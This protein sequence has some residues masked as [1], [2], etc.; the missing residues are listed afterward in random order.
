[1]APCRDRR[2]PPRDDPLLIVVSCPVPVWPCPAAARIYQS[3][4]ELCVPRHLPGPCRRH[5]QRPSDNRHMLPVPI[6]NDEPCEKR[7]FVW[8]REK[9]E[10]QMKIHG[11]HCRASIL[12]QSRRH[13]PAAV[14]LPGHRKIGVTQQAIESASHFDIDIFATRRRECVIASTSEMPVASSF[15][16]KFKVPLRAIP[17]T[18]YSVGIFF[19]RREQVALAAEHRQTLRQIGYAPSV[20]HQRCTRHC[21]NAAAANN[22]ARR[23]ATPAAR[24]KIAV[25]FCDRCPRADRSA[26]GSV[27]A[28]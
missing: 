12:S 27:F 6:L 17:L 9:C 4:S 18:S 28:P 24:A 15:L 13:L 11:L 14:S 16:H 22:N 19:A 8:P 1:M 21:S 3:P 10:R 25:E 7:G 26:E 20:A 23:A 5:K 2:N